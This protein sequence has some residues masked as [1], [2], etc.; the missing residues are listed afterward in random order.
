M[1]CQIITTAKT[2]RGQNTKKDAARLNCGGATTQDNTSRKNV[3]TGYAKS[4]EGIAF[5]KGDEAKASRHES[6]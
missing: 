1:R 3:L 2:A 5:M 6:K 4:Q